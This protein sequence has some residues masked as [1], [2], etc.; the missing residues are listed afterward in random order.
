MFDDKPTPRR[1][2]YGY[3]DRQNLPGILRSFDFAS[4]DTTTAIRFQTTVPQ[5]A[6]FL[7]NNPFL[8][9]LA[10]KTTTRSD[11]T[12]A[13]N[14]GERVRWLYQWIYQRDPTPEETR[15]ALAFVGS[16]GTS[17]PQPR[18]AA[19]WSYGTGR[20]DPATAR[21]VD[22]KPFPEFKD[23]RWQNAANYPAKGEPSHAALSAQGGHPGAS[24]KYS[25]LRRWTA[26]ETTRISV[27]G[28][29]DH[30]GGAGDGVRARVVSH[31]TGLVAEWT[32]RSAKIPTP[33]ANLSVEAGETVDFIVDNIESDNTD[34]FSWAPILQAAASAGS[35]TSQSARDWDAARDFRGPTRDPEPLQ[36]WAKYA[37]VLLSG[38]EFIFVD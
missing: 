37:Q 24:Q 13:S 7:M 19:S 31:R 14:D 36:P 15:L 26:P 6:L 20:F 33:V 12:E 23:N 3:I 35:A 4:P 32:A 34:S 29:L 28:V 8:I 22:F 27:T 17:T 1:T 11:F 10:R 38:N 16:Q 18:P 21:T 30:P 25:V 5:Q 9:E 2:L